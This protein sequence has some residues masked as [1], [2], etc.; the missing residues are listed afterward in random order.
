MVFLTR[1]ILMK[2]L[3]IAS[4]VALSLASAGA[5]AAVIS[6]GGIQWDDTGLSAGGVANQVNF[7]QW[8]I[9]PTATATT[10]VGAG[11]GAYQQINAAVSAGAVAGGVGAELVGLGEFYSFNDSRVPTSDFNPQFCVVD[12]CEL[13]FSF[14]GL[15]VASVGGTGP[16]F[17]TSNAWFNIYYDSTPDFTTIDPID[18]LA[19]ANAYTKYNEAQNEELW[20]ALNFDSFLLDGTILGG[21]A[22]ALLSVREGLGNAEAVAAWNYNSSL[23]GSDIEF[24]AGATF[25]DTST[26][27]NTT[28]L[29]SRD[30]NGQALNETPVPAPSTIALFGLGLL[31]I[32]AGARRK[33]SK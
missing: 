9:D 15:I 29:Y 4:A 16:I 21:E 3:L 23:F 28:L 6:A 5:N 12:G 25:K 33:K 32:A 26:N 14:G 2:K 31:G 20:L 17:D 1:N 19:G 24:T 22:E 30:G 10:T 7:Q 13:T 8:F 18:N 11:S 27:P